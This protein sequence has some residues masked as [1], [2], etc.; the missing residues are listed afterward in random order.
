MCR[1]P[2][3]GQ[4]APLQ[5][6]EEWGKCRG[7]HPLSL[8]I[9]PINPFRGRIF[10]RVYWLVHYPCSH[11]CI[12]RHLRWPHRALPSLASKPVQRLT[13]PVD[14]IGNRHTEMRFLSRMDWIPREAPS[15]SATN[16]NKRKR[17]CT[18]CRR[19][20]Q[21]NLWL[22]SLLAS[23]AA[24]IGK[25]SDYMWLL[26]ARLDR[27]MQYVNIDLSTRYSRSVLGSSSVA[28]ACS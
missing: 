22:C 15:S 8:D 28:L 20:V 25:H 24:S 17:Q 19:E 27:R 21:T 2:E 12:C 16:A 3:Q 26:S 18:P 5:P 4:K 14:R 23:L 11:W 9:V 7:Q 13:M 10:V 1:I 6:E